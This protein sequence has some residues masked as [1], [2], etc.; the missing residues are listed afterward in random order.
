MFRVAV[1]VNKLNPQQSELP[2]TSGYNSSS[3]HA[4]GRGALSHMIRRLPL[5]FRKTVL[6]PCYVAEGVISPF[7][8]AHYEIQ[9]YK[10]NPDLSPCVE[11]LNRLLI[12]VGGVAVV[13]IIHYFGLSPDSGKLRETLSNHDSVVVSDCAHALFNSPDNGH[14]FLNEDE[15]VL[16][17]L[18]K[19]LPVSDGAIVAS[20]RCDIDLAIDESRMPELPESVLSSYQLHL[21]NARDLLAC[22]NTG[23][24]I[25]LL[26]LLAENYQRYYSF[27][28]SDLSGYRQSA[29]SCLIEKS[30]RHSEI[31]ERRLANNAIVY[32]KL[33]E[34]VF[35]FVQEKQGNDIVPFCVPVRVSREKRKQIVEYSFQRGIVLSTLQEKWDFVPN[36]SGERFLVESEFLCEHLLI[37]ISEFLSTKEVDNMVHELNDLKL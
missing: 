7:V 9:F 23:E 30:L 32:D 29:L 8:S 25:K 37:P 18:N 31:I 10:L 1:D 36:N 20:N 21:E 16:Y 11:D 12:N 28:N 17:S 5:R 26:S 6:L 15:V 27:I 13:V 14:G 22:Q 35:S 24:S 4:T 34:G 2:I 3:R 19:F 33:N